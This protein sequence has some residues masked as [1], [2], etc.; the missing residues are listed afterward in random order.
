VDLTDHATVSA[1][2]PVARLADA[3]RWE[4]LFHATLPMVYMR[5]IRVSRIM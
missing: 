5:I 1:A 4:R 3:P 2:E